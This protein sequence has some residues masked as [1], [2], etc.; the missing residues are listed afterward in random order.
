MNGAVHH[1]NVAERLVALE[2]RAHECEQARADVESRLRKIERLI[3]FAIGALGALQV[4]L[5][6]L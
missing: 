3:W 2:V 1:F 6:Y 4:G 5:K